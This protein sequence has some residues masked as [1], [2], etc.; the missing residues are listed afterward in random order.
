MLIGG[1]D[2]KLGAV[3]ASDEPSV[4]SPTFTV[5]N[6]QKD[7]GG[8]ASYE[9]LFD[10]N[11]GTKYCIDIKRNPYVTFRSSDVGTVVTC[12]KLYTGDDT[13]THQ[14]RNPKSWTLYG[15]NNGMDWT[16]IH[17]VS[18]DT[19]MGVDNK[20]GYP[21]TFENTTPYW[22]YKLEITDRQGGIAETSTEESDW[23][24]I[25][26]SEIE[27]TA[28][29]SDAVEVDTEA[30]L[31][32]AFANGGKAKLMSDVTLTSDLSLNKKT[33]E[34]DLN[35]HVISGKKITV[36]ATVEDTAVLILKD[37]TP[38]ATHTDS[39][40]PTGGIIS[41]DLAF[42]REAA[43]VEPNKACLYANGGTVTNTVGFVTGYA[44]IDYFGTS[45]TTFMDGVSGCG[46]ILNGG[47]Y[48]GA[49]IS[50]NDHAFSTANKKV[51]YKTG[52]SVYATQYL[53][54]GEKAIRPI[55]PALESYTFIKWYNSANNGYYNFSSS[56]T[57]N[58]T[59]KAMLMKEVDTFAELKTEISGGNSV[60][61]TADITMTDNFSISSGKNV[62]IDL[63]GH[64]IYGNGK[65]IFGTGCGGSQTPGPSTKLTIIDS[66]PS[67][68][69]T[70]ASL[71]I[72]GY[73][74]ATISVTATS[75][76]SGTVGEFHLHAN[77]GTIQKVHC[78]S[79]ACYIIWS[80]GAPSVIEN[81]TGS[82]GGANPTCIGGLY[83]YDKALNADSI[84]V[85]YKDG[86]DVYAV[87][88]MS[89]ETATKKAVEPKEP[90]KK[91][92]CVFDGWYNGDTKY[93]FSTPVTASLTLSAGWIEDNTAPVISGVDATSYY[94]TTNQEVTVTDANLDKVTVDGIE[95]ALVDG[96]FTL[97]MSAGKDV[98]IVATD[99]AL[100]STTLTVKSH[101]YS[102][103]PMHYNNNTEQHAYYCLNDGCDG[104]KYEDHEFA[105]DCQKQC[106][107]CP[108]E[109]SDSE[110]VHNYTTL[111][112][113]KIDGIQYHWYKCSNDGCESEDID[114]KTACTISTKAR[115]Q[116]NTLHI[117]KSVMKDT[118]LAQTV[119][120]SCPTTTGQRT[121][122]LTMPNLRR[123]EVAITLTTARIAE[124]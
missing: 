101:N 15:S 40:L 38:T 9:N 69:H 98:V 46:T 62:T 105:T 91:A 44:I 45:M 83:Y 6:G 30:E 87:L 27:L 89:N 99:K 111:T 106:S 103:T 116:I 51:E 25:Q 16:A 90:A 52:E 70:D 104:L 95:V 21:F 85:T 60:K 54:S 22:Q 100:N 24:F 71:P 7:S 88:G 97:D 50:T 79:Y 8:N 65:Q 10:G 41:S 118:S 20:T 18:D 110:L 64:V 76:Y 47:L 2:G 102:P 93:D 58:L 43:E 80:E 55:T 120:K 4:T 81:V 28:S 53:R 39:S 14:G 92:G 56:V 121:T 13:S 63:N 84:K 67:A 109:R 59:I 108:Y 68:T 77:G 12:Y 123:T 96:K 117:A 78:P 57:S 75:A 36:W 66:N 115:M 42:N 124:R 82:S 114:H 112:Y 34:L 33:L 35:G 37:S 5:V 107:K 73:I 29:V 74:K 94:C 86:D 11:T 122:Y 113:G 72:G 1:L 49:I 31:A 119:H 17:T 61:L 32:S 19:T 48:Y 26:L 3:Y 23:N